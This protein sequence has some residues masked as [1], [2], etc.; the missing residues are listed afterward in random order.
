MGPVRV[1]EEATRS[2]CDMNKRLVMLAVVASMAIPVAADL[3]S[4]L[5][6]LKNSRLNEYPKPGRKTGAAAAKRAKRKGKRR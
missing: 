3:G 6:S 1:N 4:S 5:Y 2:V